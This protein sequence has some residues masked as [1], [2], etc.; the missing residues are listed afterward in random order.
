MEG[1]RHDTMHCNYQTGNRIV[2]TKFA[3]KFNDKND[4]DDELTGIAA[5]EENISKFVTR[6]Y[7]RQVKTAMAT[8]SKS[9]LLSTN[10]KKSF[11]IKVLTDQWNINH[12]MSSK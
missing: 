3:F 12:A 1:I 4:E 7:K 8:P 9:K 11:F 10:T 5:C 2:N 6:Y